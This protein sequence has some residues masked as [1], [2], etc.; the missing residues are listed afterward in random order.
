[1]GGGHARQDGVVELDASATVRGARDVGAGE[2]AAV[3]AKQGAAVRSGVWLVIW[4][5]G[6]EPTMVDF[7]DACEPFEIRLSVAPRRVDESDPWHDV[8]SRRR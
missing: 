2:T 4:S 5:G 7:G 3:D 1:V 8:R 6:H